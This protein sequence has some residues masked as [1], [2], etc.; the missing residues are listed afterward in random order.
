MLL[1]LLEYFIPALFDNLIQ[2]NDQS[3]VVILSFLNRV[4]T[5]GYLSSDYSPLYWNNFADHSNVSLWDGLDFYFTV[6][7]A[8]FFT[9]VSNKYD[10]STAEGKAATQGTRIMSL[11]QPDQFFKSLET[12][13]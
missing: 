5:R 7:T 6:Y 11:P 3:Y 10:K 8:L 2:A 13:N 4:L 12:K 9:S 1:L